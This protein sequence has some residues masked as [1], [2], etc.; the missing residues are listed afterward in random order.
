M[1]FNHKIKIHLLDFFKTGKFD[2]LQIGK[3]KEWI[4]NNFPDPDE[5][6]AGKTLQSATIWRYGNIELHFANDKLNQI[7]TDYISDMDAGEGIELDKWI[8]ANPNNLN[9]DNVIKELLVEKIDF[10][11]KQVVEPLQQVSVG[12]VDSKVHIIF[13]SDEEYIDSDDNSYNLNP[14]NFTMQAI[15]LLEEYEFNRVYKS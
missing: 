3:A 2:Y 11:V 9:V 15:V 8:L 13:Q 6:G 10:I 4:L 1:N 7:Y 14:N 12:L 5:F